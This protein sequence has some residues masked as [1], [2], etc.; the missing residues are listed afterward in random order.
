MEER[1]HIIVILL[2]ISVLVTALAKKLKR[3]YPIALVVVGALIGLIPIENLEPIKNLTQEGDIFQFVIISLL[4]PTLL[5][6]A[7]LKLPFS[8][9]LENK[10]AIVLLALVGT[11]ITCVLVGFSSY[12]WLGLG[13]Q[14][15]FV[16]GA[17]MSATDPVSVLSIFKSMGVNRKLSI[18][19]EGESLFNDGMA[20][21][22]IYDCFCIS[23]CLPENGSDWRTVR[24]WYFYKSRSW[25]YCDWSG[26]GL[27]LFQAHQLLR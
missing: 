26:N 17:L 14:A 27:Y 23:A 24:L 8:H 10:V 2:G 12:L 4:L 25:R 11:L 22:F 9:L 20:V 5:G 15:A 7:S 13:L 19:V 18:I 3:P 6:E 1:L 21:L 16:F